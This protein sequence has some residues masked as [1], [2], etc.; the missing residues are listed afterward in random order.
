MLE[1]PHVAVGAAIAVKFGNPY[2]ALP[3]ALV[4]HFIMDIVPH[5]NPRLTKN[6]DDSGKVPF[7]SRN[8]NIVLVDST[9]ALCGGLFIASRFLP[10]VDKAAVIVACCF[11]AVLPD[12]V[13]LP[14]YFLGVRI[15]VMT[16]FIKWQKS[17]Q[18]DTTLFWGLFT[19]SIT[20]VLSLMWI[21]G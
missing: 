4:S 14:H 21:F 3:A 5:W 15:P 11:L 12:V 1:T 2:F 8:F 6:L 19:Q 20:I 7:G 17:I 10:D 9:L 13:E 18:N 16:K